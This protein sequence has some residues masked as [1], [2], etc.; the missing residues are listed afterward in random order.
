MRRFASIA[1]M[2]VV[3]LCAANGQ[4]LAE[5]QQHN[6]HGLEFFKNSK[7][8]EA[9][10]AY[11]AGL[12][13]SRTLGT[14]GLRETTAMLTN[15]AVT[16]QSQ[17]RVAEA[18]KALEECISIE[19]RQLG[20]RGTTLAHA[21]NNIALM[22]M[23]DLRFGKAVSLLKQALTLQEV[24]DRTRAGTMHNLAAT[25]FDM[26]QRRKAEEFF[27]AAIDEYQRLGVEFELSPALTY[28]AKIAA[29]KGDIVRAE[30]LLNRA[31]ENRVKIFG[32]EHPNVALTL[33]DLGDF[34]T[35]R[36]RHDQAI[37]YFDRALDIIEPVL[38]VDH[39]FSAPVLFHYGEARQRQGRFQEALAMYQ[40]TI[41]ILN[42]NFGPEHAR[43]AQVYKNAS[44]CLTK[45]KQKQQAKEYEV[46]AQTIRDRVVSYGK[47]TIDISAFAPRK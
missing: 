1:V 14:D 8:V 37:T 29:G 47:H 27:N 20:N 4:T 7:F 12:A 42:D 34:E 23:T 32:A 13:V 25:Y 46:R 36:G 39:V 40:R 21:L 17:G 41:R 18:R 10:Q 16:L 22:D 5:A 38:G 33:A 30:S 19:T 15:L 45:L 2:A 6:K 28:L 3:C 31:L 44:E 9:E 24:D 11:R 43:L 35:E 26:G